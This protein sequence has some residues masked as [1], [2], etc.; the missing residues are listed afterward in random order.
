[1]FWR[2]FEAVLGLF[3]QLGGVFYVDHVR[4]HLGHPYIRASTE[5]LIMETQRRMDTVM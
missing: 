4:F 2:V 3:V 5:A 1:M